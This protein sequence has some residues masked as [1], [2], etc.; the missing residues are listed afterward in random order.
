MNKAEVLTITNISNFNF[1]YPAYW[2][3][4][5]DFAWKYYDSF[6]GCGDLT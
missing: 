6:E 2:Y 5:G 3:A 4:P 1:T